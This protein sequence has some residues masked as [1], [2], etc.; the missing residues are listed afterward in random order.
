MT[1]EL[2]RGMP[3]GLYLHLVTRMRMP[4]IVF[5]WL[6]M[7]GHVSGMDA[8]MLARVDAE[9]SENTLNYP[10]PVN[11]L[12]RTPIHSVNVPGG[13]KG[14]L[15]NWLLSAPKLRMAVYAMEQLAVHGIVTFLERPSS[16]LRTIVC[17]LRTSNMTRFSTIE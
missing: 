3:L 8:D 16:E 15:V 1:G 4:L 6:G 7:T 10:L 14:R 5:R 9:V 17:S 12:L 2:I 13:P 11:D